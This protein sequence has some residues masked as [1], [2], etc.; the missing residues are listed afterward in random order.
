MEKFLTF[1]FCNSLRSGQRLPRLLVVSIPVTND[2]VA[3]GFAIRE[4]NEY[5]CYELHHTKDSVVRYGDDV[6]LVKSSH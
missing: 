3:S 1:H 2:K 4:L 5:P 6:Q